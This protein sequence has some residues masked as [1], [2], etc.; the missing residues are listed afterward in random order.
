M[1]SGKTIYPRIY[2]VNGASPI[3]IFNKKYYAFGG[4]PNS[5]ILFCNDSGK[6]Q[7]FESDR[8][9]FNNPDIIWEKNID[10]VLLGDS[11]IMGHCIDQEKTISNTLNKSFNTLNLSYSMGGT[12][13]SL[14]VLSEYALN[15]EPKL[16]IYFFILMI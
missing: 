11:Y 4:V 10:L 14:G 1:K 8:Y 6:Y 9:G 12:L 3:T 7:I 5:K 13:N 15:L 2:S 16:V